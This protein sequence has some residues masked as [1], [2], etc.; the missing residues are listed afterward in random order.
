MAQADA[1]TLFPG[2]F[3]VIAINI[4]AEVIAG[5][6]PALAAHLAQDGRI[7]AAGIIQERE[8]I[9]TTAW[10]EAGLQ[11]VQRN[12]EGDWVSLIGAHKALN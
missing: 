12:Q 10:E 6:A 9:V 8:P 4:L 11:V 7:V 5:M 3:D 2:P 1:E